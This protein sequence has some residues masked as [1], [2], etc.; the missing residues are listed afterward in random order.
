MKNGEKEETFNIGLRI[1][2]VKLERDSAPLYCVWKLDKES[3]C[4]LMGLG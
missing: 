4:S 2:E 3:S 1:W